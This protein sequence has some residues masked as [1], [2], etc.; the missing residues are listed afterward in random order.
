MTDEI[1]SERLLYEPTRRFLHVSFIQRLK[2]QS[3]SGGL[4]IYA[5]DTSTTPSPEGG[6]WTR[7]DVAALVLGRGRFVPHWRADLHTFEVKTA[8]GL[9]ELAV[10]EANA[11][12]RFGH[13]AWLAFQ[14]MGR[15]TASTDGL[16]GRVH[17]LASH[18]GIGI[19]HFIDPARP[20]DWQIA[21]WP[22]RTGTDDQTADSFVRDR[23]P[24]EIKAQVSS[25]LA[26]LGWVGES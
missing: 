4:E 16:F 12:A 19:I 9:T 20:H 6:Q 14:A 1:T 17:K 23:F 7:P 11:Q 21:V 26:S 24:L 8:G 18:L 5:A 10:H 2:E 13:Y 25:H 22:R 15:A 3:Q